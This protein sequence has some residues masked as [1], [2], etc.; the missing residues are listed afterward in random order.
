MPTY[1]ESISNYISELFAGEDEALRWIREQIKERGLPEIMISA[2]EAAFLR[3]L[4]AASGARRAVEVG[5]HGGY[6]GTWIARGLPDD[7]RLITL[8]LL[9][10]RAELAREGFARAGV[11]EKI[12]LRVGDA[13]ELLPGL[14]AAGPFDFVFIDADKEGYPTYLDWSLNNLAP[15]GLVAAH[16]AFAFGGQV[17]ERANHEPD[18]EIIRQVN[19]RL[20]DDPRLTATIFPA[21]DGI[22][23]GA[24]AAA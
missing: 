13:S 19:Q 1:N 7:G 23:V 16:N 9:Q 15:G 12:D 14:D 24:L 6:S 8:E 10:E 5:T 17:V 20:A 11:A 22:V 18:V 2:E 21:G 4:V 3:F